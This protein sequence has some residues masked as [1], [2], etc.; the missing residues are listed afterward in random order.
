MTENHSKL[1][2]ASAVILLNHDA[3]GVL[4]AQRNPGI[5][6]LGGFHAFPGGKT[7]EGD[8]AIGVSN[9][10]AAELAP[11]IVGAVREA[12]EET[13]ILLVR[14]GDKLTTGQRASLH[15]DLVSGRSTFAEILEDW[16]LWIDAGDFHYSGYWTTPAFS[17]VRFKTYFFIARCPLKQRPYSAVDEMVAVEFIAPAE[18]MARWR[19]SEVLIS[20]P[21]LIT[22]M[23]LSSA[24]GTSEGSDP[25]SAAEILRSMSGE[26]DG[27]IHFVEINPHTFIIPLRTKTLPPATHTNCFIVGRKEFVVIDA[28]SNE[29]A[30]QLRLHALVDGLVAEGGVCRKIYVS[31]LHSDHFGGEQALKRHLASKHG[32]EVA[33]RTHL[34]TA[35]ALEGK[36]VFDELIDGDESIILK[37]GS[38]DDFTLSVLHTPGHARG[39]L[40]FYDEARGFLISCDNVIN[41][42]SVVIAPPEGDMA[43]YLASLERMKGLPGLKSLCGSHGTAVY[44]AGKKIE[45]YIVHRLERERQ[46]LEEWNRGGRNAEEIAASLYVGLDPALMGLAR[47]S[48]EAHIGKLLEEGRIKR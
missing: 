15:D 18:A 19:R 1:T 29:E 43:Q 31:H 46:V 14:G 44:D 30:E 21:V 20:P 16:D 34:L 42:G 32:M 2:D 28:A 11:F 47:K 33:I 25:E 26:T 23:T 37:D 7:D 22:L 36:A 9:L 39:H 24:A 4:W 48:V 3:S 35:R 12:F 10:D 13:G 5:R 27:E 6:F 41:T 45:Q 40:C 38:G 17:P 8:R